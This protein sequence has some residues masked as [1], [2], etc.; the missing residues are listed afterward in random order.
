MWEKENGVG[1][2]RVKL[3]DAN[4]RKLSALKHKFICPFKLAADM[5]RS[6]VTEFVYDLDGPA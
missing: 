5:V 2:S 3:M 6:G 4:T 1:G